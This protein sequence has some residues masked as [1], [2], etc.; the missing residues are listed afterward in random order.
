MRGIYVDINEFYSTKEYDVVLNSEELI[1]TEE[2][3]MLWVK[4]RLNQCRYN[5][6]PLL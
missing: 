2:Y 6:I 1:D 4:C 3:L 5:W